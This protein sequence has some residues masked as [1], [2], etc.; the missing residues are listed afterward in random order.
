[1]I[2]DNDWQDVGF[3]ALTDWVNVYTS[4]DDDGLS[5]G[6]DCGHPGHV[7]GYTVCDCPGVLLQ[8]Q[9]D[10]YDEKRQTRAMSA[11]IEEGRVISADWQL[12][13]NHT[14][15]RRDFEEWMA[16]LDAKEK[17]TDD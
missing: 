11:A 9:R 15:S 1:M 12:H 7:H 17:A 4:H 3:I 5:C 13:Y 14:M 8:E 10:D 6:D 2:N 16:E